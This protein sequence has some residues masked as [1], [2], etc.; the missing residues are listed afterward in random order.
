MDPDS[1]DLANYEQAVEYNKTTA[2]LMAKA[3]KKNEQARK[4]TLNIR[5]SERIVIQQTKMDLPTVNY[6]REK[7]KNIELESEDFIVSTVGN[8]LIV[9]SSVTTS[10]PSVRRP[11]ILHF[12]HNCFLAVVWVPE[13][14]LMF[15]SNGS[16]CY[17]PYNKYK[18]FRIIDSQLFFVKPNISMIISAFPE[19][20]DR[21]IFHSHK[22]KAH[23][24]LL[25]DNTITSS[26]YNPF[27]NK[28]VVFPHSGVRHIDYN[29]FRW[30]KHYFQIPHELLY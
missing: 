20:A 19:I 15:Y 23:H 24:Q 9:N 10:Y 4:R 25:Y 18:A 17:Y 29:I 26:F 21:V 7:N 14:A 3:I 30:H 11:K 8:D 16:I 28:Q 1:R 6:R 5:T 22:V 12:D 27:T 13:K 2:L